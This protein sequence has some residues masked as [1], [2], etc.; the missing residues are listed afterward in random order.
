M[1]TVRVLKYV[2]ATPGL[3]YG[4]IAEKLGK[5]ESHVVD[6]TSYCTPL[7]VFD[8]LTCCAMFYQSAPASRSLLLTSS[9]RS[10]ASSALPPRYVMFR[11]TAPAAPSLLYRLLLR[12]YS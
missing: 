5:P 12:A 3:S 6:S 7:V 10:P 8:S 4:Q 1:T 11:P 2:R 9:T